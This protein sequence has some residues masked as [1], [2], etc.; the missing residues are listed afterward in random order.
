ML[1]YWMELCYEYNI[2]PNISNCIFHPLYQP[3]GHHLCG[4]PVHWSDTTRGGSILRLATVWRDQKFWPGPGP[5]PRPGPEIWWDRDRNQ[6]RYQ[7]YD[8][9][10][11]GTKDR[12]QVSS[13]TGTG[14][15]TGSGTGTM[16]KNWTRTCNKQK[17]HKKCIDNLFFN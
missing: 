9:T 1:R 10:G 15:M 3:A 12:D 8:G 7:I 14:T 4:P 5:G 2:N 16:T 17:T 11:T 6:G 13:G